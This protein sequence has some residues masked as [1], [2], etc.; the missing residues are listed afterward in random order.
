MNNYKDNHE[1]IFGKFSKSESTKKVETEISMDEQ[2]DELKQS[3]IKDGL[4]EKTADDV[5]FKKRL[6]DMKR[7]MY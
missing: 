7:R 4:D 5:V 6:I 3:L 2:Y 1:K